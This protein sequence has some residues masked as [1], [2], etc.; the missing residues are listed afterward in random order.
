MK[1]SKRILS[2]KIR[3]MIDDSPDTSWLGEFS[4][5][6]KTEFAIDRE[7]TLDCP[8]Q[9]YDG[10][11]P[12]DCGNTGDRERGEYQYFNPGSVELYRS[13]DKDAWRTA[14][15]ENAKRDYERMESLERGDFCFIGIRADAEIGIPE[16]STIPSSP[17][18][19]QRITSGGLWG[20]ESDSDA[21]YLKSVEQEQLD[22]LKQQL[23]AIGFGT[24]AISKAFQNTQRKE[25]I[26]RY[27]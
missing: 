3:R 27:I 19:I 20:I 18:T 6:P 7:H 11:L 2:V 26:S 8:A 16:D 24:R 17:M 13:G 25:R 9:V 5:T 15:R 4:D 12:C 22:E 10:E 23:R 14:M 21:P 1:N